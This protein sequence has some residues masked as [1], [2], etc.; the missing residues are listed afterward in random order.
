MQLTL[1]GE[2]AL[3]AV[4]Y[5]AS[6]PEDSI[7]TISEVSQANNI[8]ENFLRKIIAILSSYEI[9][10]SQRG[11]GGGIRFKKSPDKI[12]PL[13]IIQIIEGKMALNRCLIDKEFCSNTR[14]CSV[15]I[16]WCEAQK[17]LRQ[18][19]SSKTIS[20]LARENEKR[21]NTHK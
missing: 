8:P 10:N 12:T 3:R 6:L 18:I 20:Q 16:L 5:M 19:L 11:K 1:M 13:E 14:W 4:L 2:Y 21:K 15:H 17:H 9:I 7:T